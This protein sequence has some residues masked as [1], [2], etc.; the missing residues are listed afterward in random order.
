MISG[1]I[2]IDDQ[3][4][5]AGFFGEGKWLSDYITPNN[6]DVEMLHEDLTK[7]LQTKEERAVAAWD[8]VANEVK[9]KPF[10]RATIQIEGKSSAQADYWQSPAM[11]AHTHVGN[12][13]N[14]AFLLA[15]LLR[16]DFAQSEVYCVLGNL[17]NGA[18]SGHAWVEANINGSIFILEAT[19]NDVPLL[20][21]EKG[22]RYE[23]VHYANDKEIYAVPGRTVMTPFH[24]C[25]SS[26]LRDY[27]HWAYINGG[28]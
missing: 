23:P 13:V 27:L 9:Y 7:G 22:T 17:H 2:P 28:T 19:R 1:V 4:V 5:S 26:W 21:V 11:C 3:P 12:C 20:A 24:A 18:V 6:P 25:Y 14:K 16:R 15:S 10:I 8:W